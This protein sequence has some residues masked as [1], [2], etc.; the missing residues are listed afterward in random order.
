MLA[1]A[2]ARARGLFQR[3]SAC[4]FRCAG[5]SGAA[6]GVV[7]GAIFGTL[8]GS[9]QGEKLP[10]ARLRFFWLPFQ[11]PVENSD[12]I[13]VRFWRPRSKNCVRV[14]KNQ[15][16]V[17]KTGPQYG[18]CFFGFGAPGAFFLAPKISPPSNIGP[19]S[20]LPIDP[21]PK[22]LWGPPGGHQIRRSIR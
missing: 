9:P 4:A 5:V 19:S 2:R 12:H 7:F 8:F 22:T 21:K 14:S 10:R 18:R 1:R 3:P 11:K 6:F 15:T 17:A 20:S 13:M 16:V